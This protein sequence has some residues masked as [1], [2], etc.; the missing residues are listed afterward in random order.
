M[1]EALLRTV[2]L[3]RH[4]GGLKAVDGV[5][6]DLAVG[7]IHAVIGPNGAGKSTLINLLSG[8]LSP[9]SGSVLLDRQEIAGLPAWKIA[10][11]GIGRSYQRTNIFKDLSV[12]ENL[13]LAVQA[14][15]VATR[16]LLSRASGR[17]DLLER[18][19][20]AL[21]RAG[22]GA[23][24]G[25][26]PAATLAHGEQRQLEIAMTLAMEPRLLLLDEPLAGLGPEE[27]ERMV[28]LLRS[29]AAERGVLLVEHDMDVVF[30]IADR[31]TVMVNG[32]ILAQGSVDEVRKNPAVR[33]AYLGE[34]A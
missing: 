8:D 30:T 27:S 14:R 29:L 3:A 2:D 28:P 4:F 13:A 18:G 33:D 20:A 9:S 23:V 26:R 1:A 7:E 5:S 15:S 11:L 24:D 25:R 21:E 12:I 22:L 34:E 19:R 10:R 31:V 16:A 32:R 17:P 6:L